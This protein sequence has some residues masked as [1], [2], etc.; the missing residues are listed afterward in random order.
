MNTLNNLEFLIT[1]WAEKRN[2]IQYSSVAAQMGKLQEEFDELKDALYNNDDYE[3]TDALGD[4]LV[5]MNNIARMR[6]TTINACLNQAYNEIKD[7]KGS[8][9]VKG[10]PFVKES[11]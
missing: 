9:L 8:I 4:M 7:R 2:I 5:V 10:G 1:D 6:G 3:V 11:K